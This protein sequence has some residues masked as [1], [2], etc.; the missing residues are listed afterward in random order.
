[1]ETYDDDD[2]DDGEGDDVNDDNDNE[3][4]KHNNDDDQLDDAGDNVWQKKSFRLPGLW[5]WLEG[6]QGPNQVEIF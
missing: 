3:E 2:D 5:G 6:R 1:M 4:D